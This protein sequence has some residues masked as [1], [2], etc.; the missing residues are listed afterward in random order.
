MTRNSFASACTNNYFRY[1]FF[2]N[3]VLFILI[4][5]H[6]NTTSTYKNRQ[7]F[8]TENKFQYYNYLTVILIVYS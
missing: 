3:T 6:N 1:N 4:G 5:V 7:L 8:I 2:P